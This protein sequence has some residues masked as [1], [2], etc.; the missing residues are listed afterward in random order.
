MPRKKILEPI[1]EPIEIPVAPIEPVAPVKKTRK[2]KVKAVEPVL[3]AI[4]VE[5]AVEKPKKQSRWLQALKQYNE[6]KGRYTIPKKDTDE[7]NQVRSL[8]AN[9]SV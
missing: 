4:P 2:V 7:Y 5:P 6:G 1:T 9:L 8:M 3:P